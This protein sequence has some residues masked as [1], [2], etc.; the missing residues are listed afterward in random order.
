MSV[1]LSDLFA[2]ADEAGLTDIERDTIARQ[3]AGQSTAEIAAIYGVTRRAVR[4]RLESAASKLAAL[5][6]P[7]DHEEHPDA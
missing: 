1:R 4:Y 3:F 2:R 5:V 7:P 6:P